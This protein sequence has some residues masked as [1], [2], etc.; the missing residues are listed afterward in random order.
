MDKQMRK[1]LRFFV[2][3][4]PLVVIFATGSYLVH[5]S[6]N[7]VLVTTVNRYIQE[8]NEIFSDVESENKTALLDPQNCVLLER[9]LRYEHDIEE[10]QILLNQDVICSSRGDRV[11][12]Q[13]IHI[14]SDELFSTLV[15]IPDPYSITGAG[16]SVINKDTINTGY[17]AVSSIDKAYIRSK[18]GY[19]LDN[20]F[21]RA[22]L[23]IGESSAPVGQSKRGINPQYI[24]KSDLY[25][26]EILL[27]A[28]DKFTSERKTFYFLLFIPITLVVYLTLYFARYLFSRKRS[29][30][31]E[32]K[33][34][35]KMREFFLHYQPHIDASSGCVFGV[36][37]L[38]RW[39]HPSRGI[40][41]PDL[42]IP[43]MEE[44][45]LMDE[46]T[47]YVL[48]AAYHDLAGKDFRE[49]I[50][51]GINVPPGYFSNPKNIRLLKL[52]KNKFDGI[53]I[54]LGLEITERQFLDSV[55]CE[56]ISRLRTFGID[57][58][59]DDFGTGQTSLSVLER[60]NID[61]LKIDKCF[62]D[63]IGHQSVNAPVLNAI[64]N[65]AKELNVGIIAEGVETDRQAQYLLT[66]G[67]TLH[68]GYLYAKPARIEK[69]FLSKSK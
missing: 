26:Y 6:I 38:V 58:L 65:L 53:G 64:I 49:G 15:I 23:F 24:A 3:V 22:V 2:Y 62:V 33:L 29:M 56:S 4:S 10:M 9:N 42:F 28:S 27:E 40:V 30:Y 45:G 1:Y 20:R 19:M 17:Y 69:L 7:E 68:Q 61:Y 52:Y 31:T 35:L 57:I 18:I 36:E 54:S 63:S 48:N 37:A 8:A 5:N 11:D 67:V 39:Q 66:Q 21:K 43:L 59:I 60:T 50:H 46:L 13:P 25:E 47:D 41:Y 51:L 55:A 44:Y 14:P 12:V 16:L 34:A 32:V